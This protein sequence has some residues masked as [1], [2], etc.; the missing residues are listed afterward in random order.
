MA[1]RPF[2]F[3]RARVRNGSKAALTAPKSN[4][5]FAPESGLKS[6]IAPCP[7]RADS[8]AKVFLRHGSQILRG[9]GAAIEQ[10]CGGPR[11][12]T[13]NSQA[14]L[15]AGL[16]LYRAA[17]VACFVLWREFSSCG[18]WDFC[19][20]IGFAGE[21]QPRRT[22]NHPPTQEILSLLLAVKPRPKGL[23]SPSLALSLM[24]ASALP[25]PARFRRLGPPMFDSP[26][27][28]S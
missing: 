13:P 12:H 22:F 14:I 15:A 2:F 10:R 26:R 8:V 18:F 25:T 28:A 19:N 23:V 4:F 6:D 9:V 27:I 5:R 1:S 3:V 20:T 24:S 7:F 17:I 11:R 16:R 21:V